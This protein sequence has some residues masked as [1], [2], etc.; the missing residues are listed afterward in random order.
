MKIGAF[1]IIYLHKQ[2]GSKKK[3]YLFSKLVTRRWPIW[4]E[5]HTK[6]QKV[7]LST[8]IHVKLEP[9]PYV[10]PEK[11]F[12]GWSLKLMHMKKQGSDA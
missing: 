11:H 1:E 10:E 8:I 9:G 6:L 4:E 2:N 5:I 12:D 7:V 3:E